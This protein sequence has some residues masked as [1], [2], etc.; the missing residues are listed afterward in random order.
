MERGNRMSFKFQTAVKFR[1]LGF[2]IAI[3]S[4]TYLS[5]FDEII[6]TIILIIISIVCDMQYK[7]PYC[8]KRFDVR[9]HPSELFYCPRCGE[10]LQ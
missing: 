3:L 2:I 8:N 10:K 1:T 7:C 5:I 6:G 4:L 9:T